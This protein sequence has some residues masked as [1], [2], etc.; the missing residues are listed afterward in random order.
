L[1]PRAPSLPRYR[2]VTFPQRA[3]RHSFL[4]PLGIGLAL[5]VFAGCEKASNETVLRTTVGDTTVVEN[6]AALIPDTATLEFVRRYGRP[7]GSLEQ[8]FFRAS[9]PVADSLGRLLVHDADRGIKRF[10][11]AG[12]FLNWV[13][14]SGQGPAEVGHVIGLAV[15]PDGTVAVRD[16]GN[17]RIALFRAEGE[18]VRSVRDPG[19][20]RYG[21][22]AV[23]F[24]HDGTLWVG[25]RPGW[26]R[27]GEIG[28]PRA[29]YLK[30]DESGAFTDTIVVP[31]R[32]TEDCP[33]LSHRD[34][35][36]G[37]WEDNRE[38][39]VPKVEWTLGPD[40]ARAF[41]CPASYELDVVRS[42]GSVL[43]ISK[44]W[45]P[46]PITDEEKA[47]LS[48]YPTLPRTLPDT[49]PAYARIILPGDGR[50]WVWPNQPPELVPV[51]EEFAYA[52]DR[53]HTYRIAERGAFDVFDR[54]GRWI[55]SVRLPEELHY[56]GFPTEPPVFIR[57]DTI[58]GVTVDEL[59]IEYVT[60]Y[61]VV[62]P[63]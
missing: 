58:W 33:A 52:T 28:F 7:S 26:G 9:V 50:V 18:P 54:N 23:V 48:T 25:F 61:Q 12:A 32:Y 55:G 21:E 39:W 35:A 37:F 31:E 45:Q 24:S 2:L 56:S 22:D 60:R 46:I 41:G 10:G 42:D 4:V 5:A 1:F 20:R 59:D 53:S 51:P 47:Q 13:A 36:V 14:R 8:T 38:P 62:W 44:A 3:N 6:I 29:A 11:V 49:R 15:G 27:N 40:G 30:V 34:Y 16:V 17:A 43:R 57:G 19:G 63:D